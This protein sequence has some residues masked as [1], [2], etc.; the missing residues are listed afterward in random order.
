MQPSAQSTKALRFPHTRAPL[1]ATQAVSV[2]LERPFFYTFC[3]THARLLFAA[4]TVLKNMRHGEGQV[5]WRALC[6]SGG[7]A[8]CFPF[9]F[10]V[11]PRDAPLWGL[12]GSRV[13][14]KEA[15]KKTWIFGGAD[16]SLLSTY[17]PLPAHQPPPPSRSAPALARH[18]SLQPA[19]PCRAHTGSE[20]AFGVGG[21]WTHARK[22]ERRFRTQNVARGASIFAARSTAWLVSWRARGSARWFWGRERRG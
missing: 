17:S 15:T 6:V 4:A 11:S 5:W 9:F 13:G 22:M 16:S 19:R 10:C 8:C 7:G 12:G 3:V 14:C 20:W 1:L 18:A 2:F 21:G